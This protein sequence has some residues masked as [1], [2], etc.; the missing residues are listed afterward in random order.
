MAQERDVGSEI[1]AG[2]RAIKQGRGRRINVPV[3]F[4]VRAIRDKLH[5][6]QTGFAALL[7][8]SVRT[9]Q[10]WE[11]GRREPTGAARTLLRLAVSHPDVLRELQQAL[12]DGLARVVQQPI[13]HRHHRDR[14][15]L[16]HR[17]FQRAYPFRTLL[18]VDEDAEAMETGESFIDL[19]RM[20]AA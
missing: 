4:D 20:A 17:A 18:C 7:G 1:L 5:L 19:R 12:V 2:L 3:P 15:R 16:E 14:C 13:A 6:S 8:V 11:Q 10:D 9:L